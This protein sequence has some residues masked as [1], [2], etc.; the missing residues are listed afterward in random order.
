MVYQMN[1]F[2]HENRDIKK[3]YGI[4]LNSSQKIYAFVATKTRWVYILKGI[5]TVYC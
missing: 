1:G 2:K 5:K 4:R 3:Y